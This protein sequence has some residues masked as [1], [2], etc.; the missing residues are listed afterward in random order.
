MISLFLWLTL[1]I[2]IKLISTLLEMCECVCL[3]FRVLHLCSSGGHPFFF[4]AKFIDYAKRNFKLLENVCVCVCV[5]FGNF[6]MCSSGD[7][8]VFS[9]G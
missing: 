6:V 4:L 1:L 3:F 5:C 8:V 2:R 7:Q 9:F